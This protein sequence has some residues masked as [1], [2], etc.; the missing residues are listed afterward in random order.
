SGNE[1]GLSGG[2]SVTVQGTFDDS[3]L[4]GGLGD[5]LFDTVNSSNVFTINAGNYTF[6]NSDDDEF[7]NGGLPKLSFT[8]DPIPFLDFW[9]T[10]GLVEF[11]TEIPNNFTGNNNGTLSI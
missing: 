5:V 1:F 2:S 6:A 7:A 4:I 3:V 11:Y 8:G 10:G 9:N